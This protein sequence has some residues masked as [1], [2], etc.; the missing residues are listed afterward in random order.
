MQHNVLGSSVD[1]TSTFFGSCSGNVHD[2]DWNSTIVTKDQTLKQFV[3]FTCA[4]SASPATS[5]ELGMDTKFEQQPAARAHI[6]YMYIE[7]TVCILS[8]LCI[9]V[10]NSVNTDN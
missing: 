10:L 4:L 3:G 9:C 2:D 7:Y 5:K 1:Y 6:P 8:T